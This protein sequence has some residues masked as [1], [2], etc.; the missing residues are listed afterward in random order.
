MMMKVSD[1][2]LYIIKADDRQESEI[3]SWRMM[4]YDRKSGMWTG[5]VSLELLRRLSRLVPLTPPVAA[6]KARLENV[7][8]AIDYIRKMP[9]GSVRPLAHFPVRKSLYTHQVRACNMAL[10]QFGVIDPEDVGRA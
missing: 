3:R 1:G 2:W 8:K 6:E 10:L 5:A 9:E 7:Q 4:K